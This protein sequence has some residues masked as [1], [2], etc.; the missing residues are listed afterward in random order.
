MTGKSWLQLRNKARAVR[1]YIEPM[2]KSDA[3]P[4]GELR[5]G[6]LDEIIEALDKAAF[7]QREQ[8]G[9]GGVPDAGINLKHG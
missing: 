8:I 6:D 5:L 3:C 9:I 1:S 2:I 4:M 7:E